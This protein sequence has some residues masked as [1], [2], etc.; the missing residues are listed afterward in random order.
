MV[1]T[2]GMKRCTN[3]LRDNLPR[4]DVFGRK[5]RT[6]VPGRTKTIRLEFSVL[7][8][9]EAKTLRQR[10]RDTGESSESYPRLSH[11]IKGH[12]NRRSAVPT[13]PSGLGDSSGSPVRQ[14]MYR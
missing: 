2:G 13:N 11:L 4:L 3:D 7:Q 14:N 9:E 8:R 12:H 5:G 1:R 6:L 10:L